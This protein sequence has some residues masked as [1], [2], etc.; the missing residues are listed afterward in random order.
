MSENELKKINDSQLLEKLAQAISKNESS[1]NF[2]DLKSE[3]II[4]L[5]SPSSQHLEKAISKEDNEEIDKIIHKAFQTNYNKL[6]KATNEL[7][8]ETIAEFSKKRNLGSESVIPS[9]KTYYSEF[10]HSELL[11]K[12]MEKGQA[13]MQFL[14]KINPN[15]SNNDSNLVLSSDFESAFNPPELEALENNKAVLS[16]TVHPELEIFP[17]AA[18]ITGLSLV[19]KNLLTKEEPLPENTHWKVYKSH[20]L[21][22]INVLKDLAKLPFTSDSSFLTVMFK[23]QNPY[24]QAF[25]NA[26]NA[27]C[28]ACNLG[29]PCPKSF[30]KDY[31]KT[32]SEIK[33]NFSDESTISNPEDENT[34]ENGLKI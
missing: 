2:E 19:K 30:K 3:L 18:R 23:E 25:Y 22:A 27:V 5:S 24:I 15:L 21:S 9:E 16:F 7:A 33:S 14:E 31:K 29:S 17:L 20:T 10:A 28:E 13:H 11:A 32:L 26:V 1:Q 34:E 6:L 4:R 12:E 8:V